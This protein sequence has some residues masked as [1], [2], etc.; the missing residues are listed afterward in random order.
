[1][2]RGIYKRS[3]EHREK[4]E[5]SGFQKGIYQGYGFKKGH[6]APKTAFKKGTTP[7]NKDKHPEC[8]QGKN[9]PAWKGGRYSNGC[10]YI[11]IHKPEHPFC[12]CR[13][14]VF[15][16][17]LVIEEQIGRYLTPIE[18]VHHIGEKDDNRPHMLMAFVSQSAHIRFE[19]GGNV[20][21]EEI[22]FDGR[23][24]DLS[25]SDILLKVD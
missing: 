8:A 5:K 4:M 20:N 21:P 11:F 16:H 6:P 23:K 18:K 3:K 25:R 15:E 2:P 7:W 13:N 17:R 19:K 24:A 12:D 9:N 10:G 14:Y 1:M 22:I